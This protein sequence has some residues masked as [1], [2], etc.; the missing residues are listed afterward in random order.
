MHGCFDTHKGQ[1]VGHVHTFLILTAGD[2]ILE[3]R[4]SG[5]AFSGSRVTAFI[6]I[7]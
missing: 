1:I 7:V 5:K 4:I 6:Q 2:Q 3:Q